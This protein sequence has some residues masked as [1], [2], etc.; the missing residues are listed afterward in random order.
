MLTFAIVSLFFVCARLATEGSSKSVVRPFASRNLRCSLSLHLVYPSK[1]S[2]PPPLT[3]FV[4]SHSS[5]S[6]MRPSSG[7]HRVKQRK[8]VVACDSEEMLE[9]RSVTASVVG[10]NSPLFEWIRLDVELNK[11]FSYISGKGFL[12]TGPRTKTGNVDTGYELCR[13]G[14]KGLEISW[15]DCVYAVERWLSIDCGV[16]ISFIYEVEYLTGMVFF[17]IP[18]LICVSFGN[19][20]DILICASFGITRLICAS[21]GITRLICASFG[22]TR[23]MCKGMAR[24]RPARGKKDA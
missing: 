10:T 21:F 13:G 18:R 3:V 20:T 11:E 4:T 8:T 22:I 9:F 2:T 5:I 16:T 15:V 14:T 12:T 7:R 1:S 19:T 24:G 6:V 17:E 23:L